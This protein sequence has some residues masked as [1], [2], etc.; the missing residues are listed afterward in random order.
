M[1]NT[2]A[3]LFS[4]SP[5]SHYSPKREYVLPLLI[6]TLTSLREAERWPW[7]SVQTDLKRNHVI[8]Y[9]LRYLPEEEAA[10]WKADLEMELTRLDK[11]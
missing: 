8:P 4:D 2:Q 9:L 5:A 11:A 10:C 7:P 3:D 6:E 1:P